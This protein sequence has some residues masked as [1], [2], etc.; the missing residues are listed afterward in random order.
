M[1]QRHNVK[2]QFRY[3]YTYHVLEAL[4]L[5]AALLLVAIAASVTSLMVHWS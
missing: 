5:P 3:H 2:R 1:A 4:L